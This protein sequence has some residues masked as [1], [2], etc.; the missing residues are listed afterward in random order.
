VGV[1][2]VKIK[3]LSLL[4]FSLIT[5][6]GCVETTAFL[7]PALTVGTSG[8]VYQASISYASNNIIYKT[9]GKSTIEHVNSFL[10]PDDEF[11]GDLNLILKKNVADF[12]EVFMEPNKKL[13]SKF[14]KEA[15]SLPSLILEDQFIL[16]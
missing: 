5:L 2:S 8:N 10:D 1:E 11:E 13:F 6:N 4:F 14:E 12:T 3:K 7:G 9:T 16:F 15:G